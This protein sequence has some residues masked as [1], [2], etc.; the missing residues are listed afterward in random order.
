MDVYVAS[1]DDTLDEVSVHIDIVQQ[2][3]RRQLAQERCVFCFFSLVS[4]LCLVFRL[5]MHLL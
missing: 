4:D 1:I 2:F 5:Y 3:A